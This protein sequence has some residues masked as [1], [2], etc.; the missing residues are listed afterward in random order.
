MLQ[1]FRQSW[2]FRR[3]PG[4]IARMEGHLSHRFLMGECRGEKQKWDSSLE[5]RKVPEG[6]SHA[7][8][9]K[10]KALQLDLSCST[11][12][13]EFDAV[14]EAGIAGGE[15]QCDGRDL[16]WASH[17]AAWDLGFE[18]L[19]GLFSQGIEDRRVDGSRTKDVHADS[20]LLEL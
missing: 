18:E 10:Y 19:F 4:R 9:A 13:E 15:E 12:D 3:R 1:G 2:K 8:A 20:A 16:L 14:D 11:V 6:E 5:A 17:L 7:W